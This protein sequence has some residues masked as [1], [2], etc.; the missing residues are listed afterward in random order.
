MAERIVLATRAR[1]WVARPRAAPVAVLAGWTATAGQ[2]VLRAM[3]GA[4]L[5]A[6][7]PAM[8]SLRLV[9]GRRALVVRA[10]TLLDSLVSG[11][12]VG[13]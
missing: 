5:I 2:A 13:R 6:L 9:S 12:F 7:M 4:A 1:I 3:A 11:R 10:L 8:R